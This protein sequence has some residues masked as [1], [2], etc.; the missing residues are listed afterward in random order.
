M[1]RPPAGSPGVVEEDRMTGVLSGQYSEDGTFQGEHAGAVVR[2]TYSGDD[3]GSF[4]IPVTVTGRR[5]R[6][7]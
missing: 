1:R 4:Q 7:R 2:G 3:A 6:E 5:P